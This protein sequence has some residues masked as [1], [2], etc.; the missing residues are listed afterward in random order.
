LPVFQFFHR[1]ERV[2]HLGK[3]GSRNVAL[4]QDAGGSISTVFSPRGVAAR[5]S[6]A[7]HRLA[8]RGGFVFLRWMGERVAEEGGEYRSEVEVGKV[9][10]S[11]NM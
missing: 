10:M 6:A 1:G 8:S 3:D 5:L 2:L 4:D 9:Q 7:S 11:E